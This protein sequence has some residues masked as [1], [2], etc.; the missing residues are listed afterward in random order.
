MFNS[1]TDGKKNNGRT[2]EVVEPVVIDE[3]LIRESIKKY[4]LEN[5]ILNKDNIEFSQLKVKVLIFLFSIV[6]LN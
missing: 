6:I 3:S 1:V 4:N 2:K 5:K